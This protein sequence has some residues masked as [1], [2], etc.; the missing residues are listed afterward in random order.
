MAKKYTLNE[1]N[2]LSREDLMTIVLSIH[3]PTEHGE[4]DYTLC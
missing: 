2:T 4:L 1:L 3:Q